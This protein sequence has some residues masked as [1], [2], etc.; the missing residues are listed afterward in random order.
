MRI[1]AFAG[2]PGAARLEG[3][4]DVPRLTAD[5][6]TLRHES[7][8]RQRSYGADGVMSVARVDW[9][10]LPLRS[11]GG[12]AERTDPG[13]PGLA[14]FE[15]TEWLDQ[16][17]YVAEVLAGIPAQLRAV[18]MM[19]LGPG[20]RS[21]V[22]VD[23]KCG[24]AWGTV[25]MHIPIVTY[26]Q[27]QLF[28]EG[29]LHQWQPG[30]FWFGDFSRPHRVSNMGTETRVHL[31]IDALPSMELLELFPAE[32]RQP[33]V[34]RQILFDR[35]PVAL[36][37]S[38]LD[39]CLIQFAIPESF[40]DWEETD[41]HFLVDPTQLPAAVEVHDGHPLLTVNGEPRFGLVHLG[42]LEFRLAGWTQERTVQIV[43]SAGDPAVILRTRK[44]SLV[45][46]LKVPVSRRP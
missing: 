22:H 35:G 24:M 19:A 39:Q 27:A 30:T 5:L 26:P 9:R 2:L 37:A 13:G 28:I 17:P 14:D 25:R 18:R 4:Y 36:S 40:T 3:S 41:G 33:S 43:R 1:P 45:Q 42:H 16:A 6:T 34:L 7:W 31:V 38:E 10:V 8:S 46:E 29:T 23:N 15:F 11:I 32:F 44:G 21:L 12:S 20:A